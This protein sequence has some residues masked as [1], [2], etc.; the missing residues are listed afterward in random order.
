MTKVKF[1]LKCAGYCTSQQHHAARSMP[2]KEIEFVA[3]YA[4][5]HHPK[6]GHILID[7]GYTDRFYTETKRFPFSM[8]AKLTPVYI[9]KEEEA[10]SVLQHMGIAEKDV[11]YIIITHYHADHV[12]GLKDF[13]NATFISSKVAYEYVKNRKGIHAVRKAFLPGL[14]PDNFESR[15]RTIDFTDEQLI[16]DQLGRLVDVFEDGSILLCKMDGHAAGQIGAL[17]NSVKGE[18]LMVAD[19]AWLRE[20]YINMDLPPPMVKLFF[21]SWKDFKDSLKRINLFHKA[22]PKVAIIPCHC[23]KTFENFKLNS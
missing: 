6:H 19:G 2:K 12:A 4:Y 22:N 9:K 18:I 7:T 20:N 1:Q 11:N 17:I 16:H 23:K 5:I 14:L 13:P 3:T 10:K 15:L 8:Y 21:D